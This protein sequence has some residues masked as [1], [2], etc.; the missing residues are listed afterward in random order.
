MSI[1]LTLIFGI[2]RVVNFAHGVLFMLG[3]YATLY[4]TETWGLHYFLALALVP[5]ILGALGVLLELAIFRRFRG[6]LLEGAVVAIAVALLVEN[7]SW[8]VFSSVPKKVEG[9]FDGSF[10]IAGVIIGTHRLFVVVIALLLILALRAFVEST[11][12]GR[13]MRALQQ[14]P[15]AATLQGIPV[16][17]LSALAFGIGAAL[18]GGAGA[19][20]APLQLLLPSMG[21][22][23]LLFS[24]VVIILGGMG[25]IMGALVASL[26]V[27]L[28][29]STV[30]TYWS[31]PAAVGL[32]FLIAMVILLFKPRGLFGHD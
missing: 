23:P 2:I 9:P 13:G 1:G 14:D 6:L 10:R 21:S 7:L 27:G 5:L 26:I 24:F 32:S 28:V 25:S 15:Y 19:L 22:T 17:R 12:V 16:S 4:I 18:A 8:Q 3:A 30:S 31:P 29:Q 11:Q 20:M